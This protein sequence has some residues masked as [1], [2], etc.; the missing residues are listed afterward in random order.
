MHLMEALCALE[1][2]HQALLHLL[3][4][5]LLVTEFAHSILCLLHY[6]LVVGLCPL[7]F[8]RIHEIIEVHISYLFLLLLLHVWWLK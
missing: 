7:S 1:H 5:Y 3:L 2:R 6:L 8:G 4:G